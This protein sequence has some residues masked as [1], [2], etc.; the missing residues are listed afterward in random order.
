MIDFSIFIF[1]PG[2]SQRFR[3][4]VV[5]DGMHD[6]EFGMVYECMVGLDIEFGEERSCIGLVW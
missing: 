5:I 6:Y 4:S 2:V 3:S 1:W